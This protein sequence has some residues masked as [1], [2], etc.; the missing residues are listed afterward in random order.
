MTDLM[1][2]LCKLTLI[3][4]LAMT[5]QSHSNEADDFSPLPCSKLRQGSGGQVAFVEDGDTVMLKDGRR[6]RLVGIQAPKIPLGRKGFV[7][8]PLGH[9]AREA[10]MD[11]ILGRHVELYYGGRDLDRYG[12]HLAHLFRKE[13]QIWI[14]GS[15]IQKGM[16]RVYSFSD[17]RSCIQ[18]LLNLEKGARQTQ[19]GMWSLDHYAPQSAQALPEYDLK[20]TFQLVEGRIL[21][22]AKVRDRIYMNFGTDYKT[23]FT[24]VAEGQQRKALEKQGFPFSSLE[25]RDVRIRG[26]INDYN[27]PMIKLTHP[28]QMEF[29]DD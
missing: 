21:S 28:E 25:N 9:N 8:W 29:L 4:F 12:R 17:N 22:V 1:K 24:I 7:A 11:L 27:G 19:Q 23:D 6:V 20:N 5:S 14:Q 13:D 3:C 10:L 15:M 18:E 2:K 16:A 26:W